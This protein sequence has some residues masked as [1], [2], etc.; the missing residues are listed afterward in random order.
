[1]FHSQVVLSFAH[2]N[3]KHKVENDREISVKISIQ[4]SLL[5]VRHG[6]FLN[7]CLFDLTIMSG[8]NKKGHTT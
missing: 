4:L 7:L 3:S 2:D 1:M 8:G 5:K 6:C